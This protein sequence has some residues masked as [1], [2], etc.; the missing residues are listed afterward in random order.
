MHLIVRSNPDTP[1]GA[2][3][4][5]RLVGAPTPSFIRGTE[6]EPNE[7]DPWP[8]AETG[9]DFLLTLKAISGR[10]VFNMPVPDDTSFLQ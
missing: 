1:P 3:R 10:A 2:I 8:R 9:A 4:A 5:M 6:E 7:G